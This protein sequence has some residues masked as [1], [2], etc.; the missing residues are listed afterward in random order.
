[1]T[2][3]HIVAFVQTNGR[4]AIGS[5]GKLPWHL[6]ED[7]QHFK[8]VT[9]GKNIY[10][11]SNTFKS[12]LEYSKGK[13][14]LPNRSVFVVSSTLEKSIDLYI[15]FPKF[16]NVFYITKTNLDKAI[17]ENTSQEF[18]IVGGSMLYAAY[19]PD[20]IIATE[21]KMGKNTPINAL[22]SVEN[23]DAFYL[24]NLHIDYIV[25]TIETKVAA[26]KTTYSI[27]KFIKRN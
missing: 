26:N 2:I 15:N 27:I 9:L 14:C 12:I 11:G 1:M 20:V 6:P 19:T 3:K 4:F 21:V 7:L 5:N 22:L 10:M 8:N 23:A 24:D 16:D 17:L 18:I 25:D 13:S